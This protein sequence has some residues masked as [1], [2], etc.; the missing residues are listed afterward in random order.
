MLLAHQATDVLVQP[1]V[2]SIEI[3]D[4]KAFDQAVEIGYRATLEALDGLSKPVV[5]LRRRASLAEAAPVATPT[6]KSA[7]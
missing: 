2:D 5:D 4:W 1:D 3:R 7:V 6:P